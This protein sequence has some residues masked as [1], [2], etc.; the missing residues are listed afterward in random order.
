MIENYLDRLARTINKNW[1]L[2]AL[3]DFYLTED[4]SAQNT[5]RGN[6]YTYGEMYD[7]ILHVC[8]IFQSLGLKQG[9]H[10]AICGANSA[11]WAIAYLSI[12][13][14]LGVAVTI[15]HSQSLEDIAHQIDFSDAKALFTDSDLWEEL[16][17][18]SLPQIESV[19]NLENWQI[20]RGKQIR[21]INHQSAIS[22]QQCQFV[23]GSPDELAM[24]CFTSGSTGVSKGVMLSYR[25]ISNNLVHIWRGYSI[26]TYPDI[27]SLLPFAHMFGLINDLLGQLT[28]AKH[29][30]I[31][32]HLRGLNDI[33]NSLKIVRP[34]AITIIPSILLELHNRY[35]DSFYRQVCEN[36][37][38]IATGGSHISKDVE[39]SLLEHHLPLAV[40]YG[41]TETGPAISGDTFGKNKYFSCGTIVV[42]MTARIADSGEILVKGE[43]VML[44]YY[45]DP[46]ATA[47]KIDKDGWLHTGDKGHLDEDG[48]LYVEGRLEQDMIVL[49]NGENIHPEDIERKINALPEVSESL[50]LAR[51]GH[52]IAIVFPKNLSVLADF[53]DFRRTILRTINPVLPMYSQLYDVEIIDTPLAKTEKQTIKR[54]LYK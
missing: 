8:D 13:A 27:F 23:H 53:K 33:Y 24:I 16:Q 39:Q 29:I 30:Y 4:G 7:E 31:G 2:P 43:N 14:Y 51:D 18:Q 26:S 50:I 36:C 11:H 25:S 28:M 40:G 42:G 17:D 34:Y 6:H 5:S 1:D 38:L 32:A 10:I 45:K 12:A 15:L 19:I 44:G 3:S 49:P 20:L 9:D 54:Y 37:K 22:N 46:E 35:K 21:I 41:M 52:L 47:R 48:Y